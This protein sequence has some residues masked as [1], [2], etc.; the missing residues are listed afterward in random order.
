MVIVISKWRHN[1][2]DGVSN[3]Q[4]HDCLLNCLFTR[5][6]KKTSKLCVTG[7]CEGNSPVTSEFPA[8]RASNVENLSIWWCRHGDKN[9]WKTCVHNQTFYCPCWFFK[10]FAKITVTLHI[11]NCFKYGEIN[12]SILNN[13]W[14]YIGIRNSPSKT[15]DLLILQS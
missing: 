7:L 13:F 10:S 15:W 2:S 14:I 4:P 5:R 12:F 3:H 9:S 8:Q 1:E 11:L 6:S